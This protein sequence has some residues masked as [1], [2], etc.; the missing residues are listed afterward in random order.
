MYVVIVVVIVVIFF[1]FV[2][3]IV[4]Y[5]CRNMWVLLVKFL[6]VVW[7]NDWLLLCINC[8]VMMYYLFLD[9]INLK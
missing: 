2:I 9:W 3:G 5:I 8:F 7:V 6:Y 1:V 4:L